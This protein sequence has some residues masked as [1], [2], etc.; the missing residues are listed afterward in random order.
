MAP[1]LPRHKHQKAHRQRWYTTMLQAVSY[2]SKNPERKITFR[3]HFYHT[4]SLI[5]F[6]PDYTVGFGIAPNHALR[7]AG[8]PKNKEHRRWGITPRP[9]NK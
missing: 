9:E 8:L 5:F 1:F 7:L 4:I 6:H 2:K 3:A